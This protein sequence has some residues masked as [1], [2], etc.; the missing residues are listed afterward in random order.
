MNIPLPDP[1]NLLIP[2]IYLLVMHRCIKAFWGTPQKTFVLFLWWGIYYTFQVI[3]SLKAMV[4]SQL[5]LAGNILLVF[6]ISYYYQKNLKQR[7]LCTLLICAAWMLV[8]IISV[9][10][11]KTFNLGEKPLWIAGNV[12][13][14]LC[15]LI[16]AVI[17][18]KCIKGKL[19]RDVPFKYF[20]AILL[21]PVCSIFLMHQIFLMAYYHMEYSVFAISSSIILLLVSYVVFEI[22]DW[23]AGEAETREQNHLYE[24]Q[25]ELCNR[26]AEERE[27][28][29]LELRRTRHDQ[30]NH[31][32]VLGGMIE[33]GD[34]EGAVSYIQNLLNDGIKHPEEISHSGNIVVDSLVNHKC[35]LARAEGIEFDASVFLPATLPFQSGHLAIIFGNLLQNSIDACKKMSEGERYIRLEASY[36]KGMLQLTVT[37]PYNGEIQRSREGRILT[38]KD[39]KARHGIG[40]SSVE[41]AASD[42]QGA[43]EIK[44]DGKVFLVSVIMY[45]GEK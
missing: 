1:A 32:S 26:Q 27:S 23:L 35:A 11:L 24:Q 16:I 12:I 25:L 30:K 6:F 10:I 9:T 43:V 7:C 2:L 44:D 3:S 40:L 4:P 15:M 34:R 28:F 17:A 19:H 21:I 5:L 33:A 45:D 8:E 38:L 20:I 18:D 36:L 14:E 41:L 39:D 42:Y 13:T 22:Y 37:N 31:L 29:Y